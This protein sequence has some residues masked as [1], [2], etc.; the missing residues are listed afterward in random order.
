[1]LD[2]CRT[3]GCVIAAVI[4]QYVM[5]QGLMDRSIKWPSAS[6]NNSRLINK[7]LK[8][9]LAIVS[10]LNLRSLHLVLLFLNPIIYLI[11]LVFLAETDVFD[12]FSLENIANALGNAWPSLATYLSFNDAE[13]Q[14]IIV[15]FPG[16]I[17][18]QS[19]CMLRAWKEG[20]AG[21]DMMGDLTGALRKI[22]RYDLLIELGK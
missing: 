10:S 13:C 11:L 15:A 2:F 5:R 17:N 18:R 4:G 16:R 9:F 22:G 6:H 1:M 12:D 7:I 19:H 20:Y 3:F 14:S 8:Y 21:A